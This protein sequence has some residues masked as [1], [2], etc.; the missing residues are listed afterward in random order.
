MPEMPKQTVETILS[1]AKETI[2]LVRYCWAATNGEVCANT[3]VVEPFF[4]GT[5]RDDWIVRFLTSRS[6]RKAA[7]IELSKRVALGYQYDPEFAYVT[8]IGEASII[9]DRRLVAD[10][11]RNEWHAFFPNGPTDVD[12]VIVAVRVD[13]IEMWNPV[14]KIAPPPYGLRAAVLQRDGSGWRLVYG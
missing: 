7:E 4:S 12:A 1:A 3:R 9:D 11:W 2:A 14:R 5:D 6:S 8:L 13:R 10:Y